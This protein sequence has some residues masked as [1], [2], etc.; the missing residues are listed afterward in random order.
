MLHH[1]LYQLL[2]SMHV[3]TCYGYQCLQLAAQMHM[4]VGRV[5]LGTVPSC[6]TDTPQHPQ[7][8]VAVEHDFGLQY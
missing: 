2:H 8:W 7:Q 5:V 4:D 6:A 3:Q 1:L